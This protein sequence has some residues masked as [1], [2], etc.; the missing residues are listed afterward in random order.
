MIPLRSL[1]PC[2]QACV[3][4][5][6]ESLHARR[7]GG[8]RFTINAT[9]SDDT[10]TL[11]VVWY[12][13]WSRA[14]MQPGHEASCS[15]VRW[16]SR[17]GLEMRQPEFERLE[18]ATQDTIHAGR[19]VP[20]YPLTQGVSQKWLRGLVARALESAL[21][22]VHEVLPASVRAEFPDRAAAIRSVTSRNRC[23]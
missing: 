23:R 4:V 9:V 2:E 7:T 17:A 5:R 21:R 11:R 16:S 20:L 3:R 13:A 1:V 10:G 12:N 18:E 6:L 14:S 22:D 19:I 15:P 8:G